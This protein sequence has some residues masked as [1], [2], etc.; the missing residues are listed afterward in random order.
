MI[1]VFGSNLSGFH[2]AGAAR[3]AHKNKGAVMGVGEGMT[4]DCYA[5]PTKGL[6]ITSMSLYRISKHI[7]RFVNYAQISNGSKQ[8]QVTRVGTGLSGFKDKDIAELFYPYVKQDCNL[9]F[10]TA[11]KPYLPDTAKFWG[12]F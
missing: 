3:Y 2:G 9:F 4:G 12:T 5:L 7:K 6:N 11:W 1:F 10:D 8:Y